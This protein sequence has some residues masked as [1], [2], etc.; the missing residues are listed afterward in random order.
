MDKEDSK[1]ECDKGLSNRE[2]NFKGLCNICGKYGHKAK[3]CPEKKSN[4][5]KGQQFGNRNN[6]E[7]QRNNCTYHP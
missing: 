7:I 3:F 5:E 4:R 1:I 6:G 2:Q